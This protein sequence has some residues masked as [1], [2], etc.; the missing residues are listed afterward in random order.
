MTQLE[1]VPTGGRW[2]TI[3]RL[4][5]QMRRLFSATV[6]C[7]YDVP[8]AWALE[9]VTIADRARLWWDPK[10]PDQ[11]TLWESTVT[12]SERFFQEVLAAA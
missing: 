1:L 12:L 10:R 11:A 7:T 5:D 9:T 4:R 8:G 6:S 3:T 2:G